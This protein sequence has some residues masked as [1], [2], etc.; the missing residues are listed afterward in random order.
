MFKFLLK[1]FALGF[2][3]YLKSLVF[4]PLAIII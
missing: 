1:V 2:L 4:G 3:D